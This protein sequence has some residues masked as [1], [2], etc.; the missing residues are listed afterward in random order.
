MT[1]HPGG[2]AL[3][4]TNMGALLSLA[5]ARLALI[6]SRLARLEVE[7]KNRMITSA[8]MATERDKMKRSAGSRCLESSSGC[9]TSIDRVLVQVML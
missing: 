6:G 1:Q 4:E 5:A 2:T 7:S 9:S 8:V 3:A